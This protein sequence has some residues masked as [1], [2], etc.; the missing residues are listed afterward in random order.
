MHTHGKGFTLV[1]L[2]AVMVILGV[3]AVVAVPRFVDL[4]TDAHR[5][6]VAGTAGAFTSAARLAYAACQA[7]NFAGRDN[8]PGFGTGT[9]DF[10]ASCYPSDTAGSNGNVNANRCRDIWNGILAIRPSISTPATDTTDYRAQGS[11]AVC[12]YTYRRA[13]GRRF[14]YN[15][16]TGAVVITNP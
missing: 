2:V 9:V 3:I 14:T 10:H 6:A 7:R 8:M 5:G 4:R 1:E 13:A 12:T 16:T 11:G 15:V